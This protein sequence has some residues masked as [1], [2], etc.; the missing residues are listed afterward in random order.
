M[1]E[2]GLVKLDTVAKA[3]N[4]IH[5]TCERAKTDLFLLVGHSSA[6][7]A[8]HKLFYQDES[9]EILDLKVDNPWI[10]KLAKEVDAG[11]RA[12]AAVKAKNANHHAPRGRGALRGRGNRFTPRNNYPSRDTYS[13]G[14]QFHNNN[15]RVG[16][17]NNYRGGRGGFGSGNF[18]GNHQNNQ[19]GNLFQSGPSQQNGQGSFQTKMI[20]WL[21]TG[22]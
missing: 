15:Y 12:A 1:T 21:P 11:K 18:Y 4:S 10:D 6:G 3:V 7:N 17:H 9:M 19:N 14:G 5:A 16:H 20:G 8:L 2:A 22:P 13:N